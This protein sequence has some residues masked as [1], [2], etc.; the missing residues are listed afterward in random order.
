MIA[1]RLGPYEI[2]SR[3]GCS[4]DGCTVVSDQYGGRWPQPKRKNDWI[5]IFLQK[6]E[7]VTDRESIN[8]K[9]GCS[10]SIRIADNS[11]AYS[12]PLAIP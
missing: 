10:P 7:E 12:Q 9:N 1:E 8:Y 5:P 3:I 6:C 4:G 2:L 11:N